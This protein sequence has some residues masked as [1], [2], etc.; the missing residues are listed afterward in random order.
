[1]LVVKENTTNLSRSLAGPASVVVGSLHV[2]SYDTKEDDSSGLTD[3]EP[4]SGWY[5]GTEPYRVTAA[6]DEVRTAPGTYA[7]ESATVTWRITTP[8][9]SY[10]ESVLVR[11]FGATPR[12]HTISYEFDHGVPELDHPAW[13]NETWNVT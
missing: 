11:L 4:R 10:A 6:W 3:Y 1:M 2:T 9:G 7:V 8:A 12:T 13:A 5:D